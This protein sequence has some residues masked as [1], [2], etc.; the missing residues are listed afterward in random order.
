M[1][2][3]VGAK[4]L[5]KIAKIG[6]E[7]NKKKSLEGLLKAALDMAMKCGNCDYGI[8]Y[9]M[10]DD[11]LE[12]S[13]MKSSLG[14]GKEEAHF[15]E[16]IFPIKLADPHV[17]AEAVNGRK[18]INIPD[19]T[20][21]LKI[22]CESL[23]QWDERNGF[24]TK[25]ALIVPMMNLDEEPI[26]ALQL[27]N[28]RDESGTIVPFEKEDEVQLLSIGVQISIAMANL[29][30]SEE[31]KQ[32]LYSFVDAFSTLI[33]ERTPY[34]GTHTRMVVNYSMLIAKYLNR[35][36]RRGETKIFID[37]GRMEQLRMAASL[38]DIGK[39]A[40]SLS[41]MNKT[42]RLSNGFKEIEQRFA[43]L[44]TLWELDYYKQRITNEEWEKEQQYL[45][46]TFAFIK[47][48]N[49]S[50]F[51]EKDVQ[52]RIQQIAAKCYMYEDGRRIFYLTD[53]ESQCLSIERGTLTI[54]ERKMME[55]HVVLTEKILN[56]VHFNEQYSDVLRIASDHH[57]FMDG[58]G[59]P[60]HL[61]GEDLLLETRILT[62]ADVYDALTATD[63]PYKKPMPKAKAL[64][65]LKEMSNEGKVDP[66][67]VECLERGLLHMEKPLH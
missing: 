38:H 36:H 49:E 12:Y 41:I 57:E 34:N 28:A 35:M 31:M 16:A 9:L 14:H 21:E 7:L 42:T 23:M 61:T 64:A 56:K 19:V 33:D 37:E 8:I 47:R 3:E 60:K 26:G 10:K 62:V 20:R 22:N 48:E 55:D 59:Y 29:Q 2:R 25:S 39:M 65:I 1:E 5:R 11:V 30:N 6:I 17:C 27:M 54:A 45:R 4:E 15:N 52:D 67:L 40:V 43:L 66:L 44:S 46:E 53:Y 32:Q 50:E 63:R 51:Q 18:A 13:M 58:S 24:R